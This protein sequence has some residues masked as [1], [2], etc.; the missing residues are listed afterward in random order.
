MRRRKPPALAA[1]RRQSTRIHT[2]RTENDH[3]H[4][5]AVLDQS[6]PGS[7]QVDLD[8]AQGPPAGRLVVRRL[9][10][11]GTTLQIVGEELCEALDLRAGQTVLDVAAGNGNVALAAARRWCDVVVDR[12]R[13]G[14][15]RARPRARRR[16]AAWRST[17]ARPTPRRCPSP[18]RSFDVVVSTFGVM[19]TPD[20]ERG[21]GASCC[22]SA[23]PAARSASPTGRPKASSA[24]S[25]RPSASTCRRRPASS[26]PRCGAR[27]RASPSCS[28][29]RRRRSPSA[30]RNF[31]FRY[32][33]PEHWLEVFRTYYGPVL[34]AFAALD[35]AGA[36]GSAPRPHRADRAVQP[37]AATARWSCPASTWRSWSP[38]R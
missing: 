4:A 6:N 35:A 19:F 28:S 7:A 18:T 3:G 27:A 21:R 9:A 14:A 12:L 13:A 36:G 30:P 20:Q 22:A 23:G 25:S 1:E 33:S 5:S 17:S 16:R 29:R 32:R 31:V 8:R 26:R 38:R 37:L 34:K 11:V 15:A 2:A 10:V 24:S